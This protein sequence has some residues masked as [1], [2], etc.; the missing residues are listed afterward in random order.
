MGAAD[1]GHRQDR[2]GRPGPCSR[3]EGTIEQA[4]ADAE[5]STVPDLKSLGLRRVEDGQEVRE[6]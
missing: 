2:A 1:D 6:P 3:R 5:R 4:L